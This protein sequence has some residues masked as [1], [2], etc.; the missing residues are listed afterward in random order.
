MNAYPTLDNAPRDI[1]VTEPEES[2]FATAREA[3]R[4]AAPH[5]RTRHTVD[6]DE[7]LA[8]LQQHPPYTDV[9]TPGLILISVGK[10]SKTEQD[11]LIQIKSNPA[12]RKT[13]III[14]THQL[15][16]EHIAQMYQ[17]GAN[18]CIRKPQNP[19][20]YMEMAQVLVDYWFNTVEMPYPG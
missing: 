5:L 14:L 6:V 2:I 4:F 3:F 12:L 18:S 7:L 15:S 1:L 19:I 13:P 20:E 16:P 8:Y 10:D 11:G 17:Q 9:A